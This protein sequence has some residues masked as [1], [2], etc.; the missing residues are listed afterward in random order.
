L[1]DAQPEASKLIKEIDRVRGRNFD[2]MYRMYKM[3]RNILSKKRPQQ[4]GVCHE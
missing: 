3:L 1:L 4:G 2:R